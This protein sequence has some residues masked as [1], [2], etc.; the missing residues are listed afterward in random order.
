MISRSPGT[1]AVVA[2]N[3][4]LFVGL[5]V[6]GGTG[7]QNLLKWG[8]KYGPYIAE[9]EYWRL[10]MPMFLH[11][12]FFHLITNLFG[13]IIFGSMVER[14]FGTRN[15]LVIYCLSGLLGNVMSFLAGPNPGVGASGGVF[16]V[17]GGF[18][19]YLL[20]NR[21]LLGQ[22]GRQQLTSVGVIVVINILFGLAISGV[23]NAAHM[24]GLI[25]GVLVGYL[26]TPR[27]RLYSL[28]DQVGVGVPRV[29]MRAGPQPKSKIFFAIATVVI[30]SWLITSY[31]S[32]T[33]LT[34]ELGSKIS[35]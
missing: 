30:I 25:A 20:I 27:E 3:I 34:D 2:L 6:T 35:R 33:Y 10:F 1:S 22:L 9:G 5:M 15:Y 12:S 19:I 14:I 26:V 29:V 13:L 11:V 24:G 16:G 32:G 7:T 21:R 4:L 17:L 28:N 18:G 31:V 8:A 23:D